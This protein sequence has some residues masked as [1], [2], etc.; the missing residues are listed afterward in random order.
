[1]PDPVLYSEDSDFYVGENVEQTDIRA[2]FEDGILKVLVPEKEVKP[3]VEEKKYI[4]IEG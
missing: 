2:K 3:A 1:M 4:M